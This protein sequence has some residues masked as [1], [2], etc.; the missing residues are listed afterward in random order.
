MCRDLK[1]MEAIG[2]LPILISPKSPYLTNQKTHLGFECLC[3]SSF[4]YPPNW[5][6]RY[7]I[8]LVEKI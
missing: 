4:R 2:Q 3:C 8:F 5:S 7:K 6:S 1:Y